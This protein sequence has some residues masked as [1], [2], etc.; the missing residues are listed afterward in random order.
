MKIV[1]LAGGLGTRLSEET[2]VKPKP[3]VEVG[4]MPILW[5]IM[6]LYSYYGFNDFIICCGYKG[7]LI[8]DFFANYYLHT[9]DI[10]VD[11]SSGKVEVINKKSEPWRVTLVDTGELTMT[12]GRLKRVAPYIDGEVFMATY[13]DGLSNINI[14]KLVEFHKSHGKLATLSAVSPP[15]RFGALTINND[16]DSVEEFLEKPD[17]DGGLINGGFFVFNKVFLRTIEGDDS[18]LEQHPLNSLVEMNELKAYRHNG[19]W[20][21]MDTLRDKV[22]LDQLWNAG[23]APWK[24]W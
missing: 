2:A 10:S 21:P 1:I 9:A 4:H 23:D 8:K 12:G 6:K 14:L 16:N 24:I 20:R 17:G 13:G 3:L 22:Y 19:F 7:Y 18:V 11:L 15:G 5:H